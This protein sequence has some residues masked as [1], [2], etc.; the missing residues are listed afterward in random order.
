[1][2]IV[3]AINAQNLILPTGT[4]KLGTLEYMVEMNGSPQ[5][6]AGLNDLPDQ[7]RERRD[8]LHARRGAYSRRI[9]AANQHRA[10]QWPARR[11]H[12]GVQNRLGIH[13]GHRQPRET[14]ASQ[15]YAGSIPEG[16]HIAMLFDQSLFVR[17]SDLWRAARSADRRVSDGRS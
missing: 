12:G 2:D 5:T 4:A 10:R 15:N 13:A 6:V 1:M 11:A 16:I 14:N 9:F 7:N 8:H 3:N 17:A